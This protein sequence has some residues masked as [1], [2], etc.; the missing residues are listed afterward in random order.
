[1]KKIERFIW[2][3]NTHNE[4]KEYIFIVV[5]LDRK[6]KIY[7]NVYSCSSATVLRG[8]RCSHCS[9]FRMSGMNSW[10]SLSSSFHSCGMVAPLCAPAA[11]SRAPNAAPRLQF[12]P[13]TQTQ[14][15]QQQQQ[16][17]LIRLNVCLF[18]IS[19]CSHASSANASSSVR[20]LRVTVLIWAKC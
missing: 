20:S 11:P 4:N 14:H 15:Q 8:R 18:D 12:S 16:P 13:G 10:P 5:R 9:S 2:K 7:L 1:M 6:S 3:L 17:N 19:A